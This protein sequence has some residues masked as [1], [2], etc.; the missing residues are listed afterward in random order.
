M[1][2]IDKH[3]GIMAIVAQFEFDENLSVAIIMTTRGQ[4]SSLNNCY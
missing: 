2:I 3:W 1:W 4:W